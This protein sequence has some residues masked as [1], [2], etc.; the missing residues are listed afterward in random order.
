MTT[1]N[2][3]T[4]SVDNT[5]NE[6]A[7]TNELTEDETSL[8]YIENIETVIAGMAEEQKVMVAQNETGHLW[9]FKYGLS[10]IH[11]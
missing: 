10:L 1:N 9:K 5:S 2:P 4:V 3:E 8:N 11:I 7:N 6:E